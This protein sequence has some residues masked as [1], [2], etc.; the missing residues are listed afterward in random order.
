MDRVTERDIE[1]FWAKVDK[2]DNGGCW[3]WLGYRNEKGYGYFYYRGHDIRAHRFSYE[4]AS[5]AIPDGLEIDHLCRN[6]SCVNPAHLDVVTR[7]ENTLRGLLPSVLRRKYALKTHCQRG[8]PFDEANTYIMPNGRR[9]CRACLRLAWR[10]YYE[11]RK[12]ATR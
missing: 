1:R 4:L 9:R 11:K 5:G 6:T 8:H 12:Q 7:S 10:R 3:N 2:P